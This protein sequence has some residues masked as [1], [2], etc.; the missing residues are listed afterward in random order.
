M[1]STK[2]FSRS[3]LVTSL[4]VLTSL[5]ITEVSAQSNIAE[6]VL[7]AQ[8]KARKI[9]PVHLFNKVRDLN[10][11]SELIRGNVKKGLLF[12]LQTESLDKLVENH[13]NE[14]TLS[15]PSTTNQQMTLDLVRYEAITPD[16]KL[17]SSDGQELAYEDGV[18][19]RGVVRDSAR[20][21]VAVSLFDGELHGMIGFADRSNLI[22]G[23]L[24]N[25]I[26]TN[27]YTL[28]PEQELGP[29]NDF[30]CGDA[31]LPEDA[32]QVR[33]FGPQLRSNNKTVR[34][35]LE[36]RPGIVTNK[37]G[38]T[39][40]TNYILGAF[41]AVAALYQN[42]GINV[43]VSEVF[44]WTTPDSYP[45]TNNTM[46]HLNAF[47]TTRPT[48]NGDLAQMINTGSPTGGLAWR[49]GLCNSYG[50]SYA[51]I[52]TT[53]SALPTYSWTVSV[54][55]H[56]MGH[57]LGSQ[58]THDCAWNG[59]NT[60][61]DGCGQQLGY[62]TGSCATGP[63]PVAGTI[64]SYCHLMTGVGIDFNQGFGSQPAERMRTTI[65]NAACVTGPV[66]CAAPTA[67][68]LT[69]TNVSSTGARLNCNTLGA[70]SYDWRYRINGSTTW[71]DLANTSANNT[72]LSA[73]TA[74]TTF[75]F[76][77]GIL[78]N[79]TWTA[80]SPSVNFTTSISCDTVALAQ[81]TASNVT[82][83]GATL[84]ANRS[85]VS[86]FDWRYRLLGA[87]TWVDLPSTTA[88]NY[89]L[90]G[91][92][93]ASNYEFQVSVQCA[94]NLWSAW[95]RSRQFTTLTGPCDSVQVA[96]LSVSNV[97]TSSASITC[98]RTGVL[99]YDFR[100]RPLGSATWF[101]FNATA[102]ST[103]NISS[104]QANTTYEIQVMVECTNNNWSPWSAI[105][106]FTTT[107]PAVCDTARV[108]ELSVSNLNSAG[109]TLNC[110]RTG[111]SGF[112]W[113]Y[114]P[115]GATTW[116]D[117]ANTTVGT[118][119]I[120]GLNPATN[121]EFQVLVLCSNGAWSVWSASRRFTTALNTCAAP[122][123]ANLSTSSVT[124]TSANLNCNLSSSS[125]FEWRIREAGSTAWT[126]L[127]G[128]AAQ[129]GVSGLAP[130]S[131]YE[132]SARAQ[133]GTSWSNWS[134]NGVLS[135]LQEPT[136]CSAATSTQLSAT[137]ITNNSATLTCNVSGRNRYNM[138]YRVFGTTTWTTGAQG[139]SN[140]RF[141]SGLLAG[142]TYEFQFIFFCSSGIQSVW[143]PSAF[144]TTSG[145]VVNPAATCDTA[146]VVEL[147]ATN[148]AQTSAT[149]NCSRTGMSG[150]D[151]R[152]RQVGL[153]TWIDLANTATGTTNLSALTAGTNYEFQV[154]VQC[155]NGVWSAWSASRRFSTTAAPVATCDTARVAELS[156]TN[157]TQTGATLACIRTAS[158]YDWR[159]RQVGSATW[160]DLANTAT[161]TSSLSALTA[162]TNYEFQALVQCSNGVWSAWS[163]SRRFSTT[164]APVATC[165]T[166][167]V[168]ELSATNITQTGASLACSRTAS[169]YDWRYRQVGSATWLDLA[170]TV[171]G[172]T[173]LSA[174][175]AGTNY[176]FQALVQCSN[177]VW[178]AWSASRRFSTTAAPV[179]TCDTARVAELSATNITQTGATLACIRTASNYDWRYR[180]VGSATWIDLANTATGTSS[181]SAL[182]AGTNYEFQALVQCSNG[183]W[184]AWSASRR[185]STT[186]APVATCDTARVAEL[187]ATN[188]T[189]TGATLACS[190]TA[191]NY[192][193]RYRQVGSATWIDLANTATGTSSLSALTAGTNYE[194]QALVQ[195][196]NGVWSAWSASRRFITAA[197]PATCD[198][199][200]VTELSVT[201]ITQTGASLACSRS[202]SN[203]DW[204]YR[205]VGS[206]TWIDLA[207]TVTGSTSLSALTAGTNYEFQVLVQCS[208]GV[209]SAWSASRRFSTTVASTCV[210]PTLTQLSVGTMTG[211]SAI[212]NCTM[213]GPTVFEWR[214]R[215]AGTSTW[216]PM[217]GSTNQA[218]IPD[219][220]EGTD[221][222]FAVRVQCGSAWSDWSPNG[223][224][225]TLSAQTECTSATVAQLSVTNI[226]VNTANLNCSLTGRNRYSVRYRVFGTLV[227]TTTSLASSNSRFVSGLQAGTRYE[228]QYRF[229]CS[230]SIQSAWS[231]SAFFT[232]LAS[233]NLLPELSA[234]EEEAEV[235]IK[236]L[237]FPNPTKEQLNVNLQLPNGQRMV[238]FRIYD[239]QG[240]MQQ[241]GNF[242]KL[243]SGEHQEEITLS[244]LPAGMYLFMLIHEKGQ[245]VQKFQVLK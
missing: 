152:Y 85:G 198:T 36:L 63:I 28:Y 128:S 22:L 141:V 38:A 77:A 140:S 203:Y 216:S 147:S 192:D 159:Y 129:V 115:I 10:T 13:P 157:I 187:S 80:W 117:L 175:T 57:N 143:S 120:S 40:A 26:K 176:E 58:H 16:F 234:N 169:N 100:L 104:M 118:T 89:V 241:Q 180:Q 225:S 208:N 242:G 48:F 213:S 185:F 189:Q 3:S 66:N 200:R 139:S 105:R 96:Q 207:N 127:S 235:P 156:A 53:Y 238:Q 81:I 130:G 245:S 218:S 111:M 116:T 199:A 209:W 222:E 17:R 193:W 239:L 86:A 172:S 126:T 52:H 8:V 103:I 181:L 19:Y 73:L 131:T 173:S 236:L 162:G 153:A 114:R 190:R 167:R 62:G 7:K 186:A 197:V 134:P 240:K 72:T 149:L 75:E 1:Y 88:G 99:R 106:R 124:T 87:S 211:T 228:F 133:C 204:R 21:V 83:S 59:N 32:R 97:T 50:Y 98:T 54:M 168:A 170:N 220:S 177:G 184:S 171:T 138:R 163:A 69:V 135:T 29:M 145:G 142:T 14:L 67:T 231:G 215:E 18:H 11:A 212:V 119:N 233:S 37:G 6:R 146:L 91:L 71:I 232:T 23:K 27:T 76:Q 122:I 79:N 110:S 158:N 70:T 136:A 45:T 20:T 24:E 65:A 4:L 214:Y 179:A 154:L 178:S 196:S 41:N 161:G 102:A 15:I 150:Y 34:V 210:A 217:N 35:Y 94:A 5:F 230:T 183:V 101:D 25:Q 151:W 84:N 44:C 219:L 221:Y 78:C 46:D 174:L 31:P 206:A 201:N 2:L 237:L 137:N 95:S 229:Y 155:S 108:A 223:V 205:Q 30:V 121:Y 244:N 51:S 60:P 144:F 123:L 61:I 64:M 113:R 191:S 188:I 92:S 49:P 148:I 166:A 224:F 33:N 182:T 47:R 109:G 112:D 164:A 42:D 82:I 12:D 226:T 194:F 74:N 39:G 195:C 125:V 132:F 55:A 68:E 107:A 202:A 243:S 160:I 93:Q 165:D 43:A 227:W 56:E 90:T 9:P